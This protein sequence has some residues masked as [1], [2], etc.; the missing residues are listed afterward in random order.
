MYNGRAGPTNA[1]AGPCASAR[2]L[3]GSPSHTERG[4]AG[5]AQLAPGIL[6]ILGWYGIQLRDV[7]G[8]GAL[9]ISSGKPLTAFL[10]GIQLAALPGKPK[11]HCCCTS[12]AIGCTG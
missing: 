1:L 5:G 3:P 9:A 6:R 4:S 12:L 11:T 8:H 7:G 10:H 2:V